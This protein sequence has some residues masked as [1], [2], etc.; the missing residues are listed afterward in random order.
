MA[1][2]TYINILPMNWE[3]HVRDHIKRDEFAL[4]HVAQR[5]AYEGMRWAIAHTH[6]RDLIH[7][8]E[9]LAGFN[10]IILT[11]GAQLRNDAPYAM[12]IERG[13]RPGSAP[14]PVD[15]IR[16][17]VEDKIGLEGAEATAVAHRIRQT[18]SVR[19]TGPK[20]IMLNAFNHARRYFIK[21]ATRRLKK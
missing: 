18:I 1:L 16:T 4:I 14:P 17:W 2:T 11:R 12:I 21:E 13:R 7:K 19:G 3:K 8:K 15:A 10:V 5:S 6:K 20:L 9:Y